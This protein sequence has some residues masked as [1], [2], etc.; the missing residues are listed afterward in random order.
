MNNVILAIILAILMT[1]AID[2]Y[3]CAKEGNFYSLF[4]GGFTCERK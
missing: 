4:Y 2:G 3:K 1:D